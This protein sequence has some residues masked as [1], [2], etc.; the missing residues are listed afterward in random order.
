MKL[1]WW[2]VSS[3]D[4]PDSGSAGLVDFSLI[5]KTLDTRKRKRVNH[6]FAYIRVPPAAK[7]V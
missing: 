1:S 5:R 7:V 6:H 2:F 4:S 3:L